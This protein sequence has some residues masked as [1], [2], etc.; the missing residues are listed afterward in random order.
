MQ[1]DRALIA[2]LL[3]SCEDVSESEQETDPWA[4][5]STAL[6]PWHGGEQPAALEVDIDVDELGRRMQHLLQG[7]T[8]TPLQAEEFAAWLALPEPEGPTVSELSLNG[9]PLRS[10]PPPCTA[11]AA[12]QPLAP[13][14][15]VP[16]S[17]P[18]SAGMRVFRDGYPGKLFTIEG[19]VGDEFAT[20]SEDAAMV[21]L[22]DFLMK[23]MCRFCRDARPERDLDRWQRCYLCNNRF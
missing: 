21:P 8:P 23:G 15:F 5:Q 10:P 14:N 4:A 9:P 20:V 6:V 22:A 11:L 17:H 12:I 7:P 19:F 18:F 13:S 3:A 2:G 1:R 16:R